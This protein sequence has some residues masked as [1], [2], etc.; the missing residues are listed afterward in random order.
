[1]TLKRSLLFG[2]ILF[3]AAITLIQVFVNGSGR[4]GE[5]R[6]EG[7]ETFRVGFLPVT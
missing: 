3:V 5:S 6:E 7:R 2:T 1:M 4:F